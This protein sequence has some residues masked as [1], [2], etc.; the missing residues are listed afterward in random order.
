MAVWLA[1]PEAKFL[2]GKFVYCNWDVDELKERAKDIED[3]PILTIG[4]EGFTSFKY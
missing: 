4:L 3:S 2:R 1:S